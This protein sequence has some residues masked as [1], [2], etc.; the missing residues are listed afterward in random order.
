MPMMGGETNSGRCF[1]CVLKTYVS[2]GML[3]NM[4]LS[5][6]L[7]TFWRVL[8]V[9]RSGLKGAVPGNILDSHTALQ[10]PASLCLLSFNIA[11]YCCCMVHA[12]T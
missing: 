11:V 9:L 4:W 12:G 7:L 2:C 5:T 10:H 1:A 3:D 8:I 6:G